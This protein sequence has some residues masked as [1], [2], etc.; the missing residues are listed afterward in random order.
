M[1][2][3]GGLS[4]V[5][6]IEFAEDGLDIFETLAHRSVKNTGGKHKKH[7]VALAPFVMLAI[8]VLLVVSG[9]LSFGGAG[10]CPLL[11]LMVVATTACFDD[12]RGCPCTSVV[13][14]GCVSPGVVV[15]AVA[16]C[17]VGV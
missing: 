10:G 13:G 7:V 6:T 9:G 14:G 17:D 2:V 4:S 8:L 3:G 1:P 12:G 15:I 11:L 16:F 5:G